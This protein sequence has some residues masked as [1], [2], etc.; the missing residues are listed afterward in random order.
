[1]GVALHRDVRQA[2]VMVEIHSRQV[3]AGV[4][5]AEELQRPPGL[6]LC[7]TPGAQKRHRSDAD[8]TARRHRQR[9]AV[10]IAG[11]R[12][13]FRQRGQQVTELAGSR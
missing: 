13:A 11:E 3:A 12:L 5:V 2:E 10:P 6:H 9:Q 4:R 1:M 8:E 7:P